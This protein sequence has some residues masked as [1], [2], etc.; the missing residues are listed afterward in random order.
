MGDTHTMM[1]TV[2]FP[3]IPHY[4]SELWEHRGV[5][6]GAE[7]GPGQIC[8][9]RWSWPYRMSRS[10]GDKERDAVSLAAESARAKAKGGKVQMPLRGPVTGRCDM[11]ELGVSKEEPQR[12]RG[13]PG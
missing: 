11:A 5:A 4:V 13:M 8:R 12:L 6:Q 10:W 9:G 3:L 7:V 1:S 2:W